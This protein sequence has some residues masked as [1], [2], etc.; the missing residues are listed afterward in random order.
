MRDS[1]QTI[2]IIEPKKGWI[3][4]D[5]EEIWKYRELLYFLTKRDI[6]VRYKQTVL[7]GLWAIIQPLFSMLIFTLLFGKILLVDE[8]LAVGH[9]QT[10]P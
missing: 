3:P 1:A 9:K 2:S 7:G 4:I 6:K 8:V 5:F 10:T